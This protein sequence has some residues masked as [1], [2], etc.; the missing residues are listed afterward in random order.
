MLFREANFVV[1]VFRSLKY[2]ATKTDQCCSATDR[3]F[4]LSDSDHCSLRTFPCCC[5]RKRKIYVGEELMDFTQIRD[6]FWQ[7]M[8]LDRLS[9]KCLERLSRSLEKGPTVN[10]KVLAIKGFPL[11]YSGGLAPLESSS[12]LLDD[13]TNR[14]VTVQDLLLALDQIGNIK[15]G[16]IVRKE[17]RKS[18][19]DRE[20]PQ[21]TPGV[22]SRQPEEK[23]DAARE[24]SETFK[25]PVQETSIG[26]RK[27]STH[28]AV[29]NATLMDLISTF[30]PCF[31]HFQH[32]Y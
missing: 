21:L 10:W 1:C 11:F 24:Q 32:F 4:V 18:C 6:V 31:G 3:D 16:E 7:D 30:F 8:F 14:H 13:L 28:T 29:R 19:M 22:S 23:N 5:P 20:M 25:L 15:A 26:N 17:L 2:L 12:Q 27:P 9:L